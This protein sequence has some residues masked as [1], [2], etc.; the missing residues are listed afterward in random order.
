[1]TKARSPSEQVEKLARKIGVIRV[2]DLTARGIH[3]EYIR[4][5]VQKGLLVRSGRGLY[6]PAEAG[7]SL[8]H[9]LAEAAKWTPRGVICLIS[10]LSFHGIGTQVPHEVWLALDRRTAK[11]RI[12]YPP[13]HIV[14][15]SGPALNEGIR[16]HRIEGVP[17]KIYVPAKTIADCFKYRNKIGLDVAMEALRDGW[18]RRKFT[19]DELWHFGRACR[20]A[21]VMR[22]YLEALG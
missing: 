8:H 3:P 2:Q 10:A 14:R 20:V 16:E 15:F 11:P 17:V 19:M 6:V 21:N 4:R 12:S 18:R 5:L 1:M 13:L 22:P 7:L 9:S